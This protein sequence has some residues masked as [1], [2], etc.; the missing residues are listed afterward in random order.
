MTSSPVQGYASKVREYESGRPEYPA[1]LLADLPPAKI[2]VDLGAGTGKFTAL[3][4]LTG[5]H[6][7]AVEPIAEMA[8]RIG[9]NR[10][11]GVEVR[12]GS[13][14]AIPVTDRTAGL[15]CCATAF[16]WFEYGTAMR[17]I[18]RVLTE[19]GALALIWNVRDDRVPW[20]KEFSAVMDEYAGDTPRQSSGQWRAIFSDARFRHLAS[21]TYPFA[22]AMNRDGVIN[23]ALSTSFIAAL[24]GQEQQRV[25]EK[26]AAVIASDPAL[27]ADT[28]S[29]PYLTELYLFAAQR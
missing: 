26:I 19:D 1:A 28:I 18:C 15:V 24:P 9:A 6:I 16:H 21:R 12:I 14:E 5:G 8:E 11:P 20:V 25:R 27:A 13:A 17:E 22:Q 2:I 7:I 10:L 23:R 4:A 3:L 29:F